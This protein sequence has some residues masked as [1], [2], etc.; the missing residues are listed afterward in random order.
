M[1]T[2]EIQKLLQKT[3]QL[4]AGCWRGE[5]QYW[6]AYCG[7]PMRR[8]RARGAAQPDTMATRDHVVPKAHKGG[9]VTVPA[10]SKCNRSKG[11]MS[12]PEFLE[13]DYFK[14]C[15]R[16][17]HRHQWAQSELWAVAG[18]AALTKASTLEGP[19]KAQAG[20]S[21]TAGQS[22]ANFLG[23]SPPVIP[24]PAAPSPVS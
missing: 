20:P 19:P 12:L 13:T 3:I 2:A 15:R 5:R 9:I 18:L 6:C 16:S 8:R 21:R 22:P 10:C 11:A 14:Q 24:T 17:K 23:H 7:I 1:K 4:V